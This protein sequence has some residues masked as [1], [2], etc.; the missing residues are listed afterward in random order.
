[1][2]NFAWILNP[3]FWIMND[4][5]SKEWD[6]ELNKLINSGVEV[7]RDS[8]YRIQIGPYA[9]WSENYPYA[10]FTTVQDGTTFRPRRSTIYKLRHLASSYRSEKF[11]PIREN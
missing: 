1:M 6:E 2:K 7:K 3:K 9:V 10:C 5:F 4:K 11:I 8:I